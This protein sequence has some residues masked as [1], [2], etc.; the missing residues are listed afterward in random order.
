MSRDSLL[1]KRNAEFTFKELK[2]WFDGNGTELQNFEKTNP[3]EYAKRRST[4]EQLGGIGKSR[5]PKPLPYVKDYKPAQRQY[6]SD[7]LAAR[8]RHSEAEVQAYFNS[9]E[10]N[11]EYHTNRNKYESMREAGVSYGM[12]TARQAPYVPVKPSEPEWTMIIS[13]ELADESNV[14][15]GTEINSAQLTQLCQ[16]RVSRERQKQE[17]ADAK[18]AQDRAAELEKLSSA[19]RADQLER[20]RK[21]AD[22]Q[23]LEQLIQ[24]QPVVTQEPISLATARAVAAEKQ[25]A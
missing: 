22:L 14:P 3:T 4:F 8:G 23:R 5:Q 6:S 21:L 7:E 20:D 10:S 12:F 11:E 19:Q 24:P 15:R 1:E 13:N 17:A 9:K 2:D 18:I 16:Q 25:A